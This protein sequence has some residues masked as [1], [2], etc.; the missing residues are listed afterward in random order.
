MKTTDAVWERP[1]AA[2]ALARNDVHVWRAALDLPAPEVQR[3]QNLLAD[4]EIQRA[5]RF[6]SPQDRDRFIVARGLLRTILSRY[7]GQE[8]QRLRF[9]YGQR[10]KPMLA[11][12]TGQA[13]LR[14]NVSHSSGMVLY[15]LSLQRE[16]GV[17]LEY[18]R[19]SVACEQ[20][21]ERFFSPQ[22]AAAL[23]A[24]PAEKRLHAFFSR[25]TLKEAYIKAQGLGL[26]LS[27]DAFDV[28]LLSDGMATVTHLANDGQDAA[29]W[30]LCQLAP[31]PHY[32]AALA[33]EGHD[34]QLSRWHW[35]DE[36]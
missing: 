20:I 16:V 14:F 9:A 3:L 6:F 1:P 21:A 33:V 15:A 10:G 23:L 26:W 22:E 25:W 13:D 29:R 2:P 7:T 31:A 35:L 34:W 28:N 8:A 24:L 12:G 36:S 30:L 18:I 32:A 17:D 19:A 27:L 4:D 11:A 5:E